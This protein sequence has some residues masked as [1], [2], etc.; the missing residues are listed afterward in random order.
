V[1]YLAASIIPTRSLWLSKLNSLLERYFNKETRTNI[2]VRVLNVLSDV[3]QTNR[4]TYLSICTLF[5]RY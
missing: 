1:N 4:Y 3:I 2:R 5:Y